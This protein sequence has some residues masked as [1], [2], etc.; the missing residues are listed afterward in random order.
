MKRIGALVALLLVF[1]F[2]N[3][4]QA[5]N[6]VI[7]KLKKQNAKQNGQIKEL[8]AIVSALV[9]KVNGQAGGVGPVGPQGPQGPS[10]PQGPGG[11]IGP[12]GQP[13]P[14]GPTGPQGPAGSDAAFS[15]YMPPLS[16]QLYDPNLKDGE[17]DCLQVDLSDYCGDEDG[18]LFR[19]QT[20]DMK[21]DYIDKVRTA[22]G[23]VAIENTTAS[24][25]SKPGREA[26]IYQMEAGSGFIN[27]FSL[28]KGVKHTIWSP[29]DDF[30]IVR[31]YMSGNCVGQD[32]EGAA[33]EGADEM[34]V[35]FSA[36]KGKMAEVTILDF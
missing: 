26:R 18:C 7:T 32:K 3:G 16:F 30:L 31:N 13:G 12:A 36:V 25:D 35:V 9:S 34:S 28:G 4:A 8:S 5:Q 19:V 22:Q 29:I 17:R 11:P 10:G 23:L 24:Q 14:Q 15:P 27:K 1:S 33:F 21:G 6:S 20:T 2:A